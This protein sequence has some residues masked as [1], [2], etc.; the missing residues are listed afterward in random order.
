MR[1]TRRKLLIAAAMA[2][3]ATRVTPSKAEPDLVW[4]GTA[5]GADARIQFA[6]VPRDQAQ[7]MLREVLSEV[8]RLEAIFSLYRPDSEL[9]RLN[10]DGSLNHPS[11]DFRLL[12]QASLHYEKVTGGAFNPAIQ[13]LWSYLSKHFAVA[14]TPPPHRELQELLA[15]CHPPG[16]SVSPSRIALRAGMALTF[17]GIAQGYITDRAAELL[18]AHGMRNILINLGE[19]RALPGRPWQLAIDGSLETFV[20]ENGAIAQSSG[21]GTPL[22]L[23]GR[24]H[25]LFDPLTGESANF[26]GAATVIARTATEADALS[27]ALFVSSPAQR[28]AIIKR[29]PEVEVRLQ[30]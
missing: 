5:L 30:T 1:L 2:L 25:H 3:P 9:A 7:R 28:E 23:D 21:R 26:I 4:T 18:A 8:E 17:N 6:G 29:F 20:L 12:L 19:H 16:V 14:Q 15:L 27:T 22:S 11:H 13:P 24:W 10:Q